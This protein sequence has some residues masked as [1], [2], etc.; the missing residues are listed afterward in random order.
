MSKTPKIYRADCIFVII[1]IA[2]GGVLVSLRVPKDYLASFFFGGAF[3]TIALDYIK[4][5]RK[6]K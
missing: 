1:C 6:Q 3:F 2:I 4:S 5:R